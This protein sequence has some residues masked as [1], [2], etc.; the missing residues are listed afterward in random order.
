M[1]FLFTYANCF[2]F[3]EKPNM[4]L[5]L[6][7]PPAGSIDPLLSREGRGQTEED[8]NN[9]SAVDLN[10]ISTSG[11]AFLFSS[12]LSFRHLPKF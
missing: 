7:E 8:N 2:M 3:R 9:T 11:Y 1:M 5:V 12:L 4:A 6:W 10:S